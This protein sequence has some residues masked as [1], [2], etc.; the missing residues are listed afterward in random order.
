MDYPADPLS[1]PANETCLHQQVL[2][3]QKEVCFPLATTVTKSRKG[4]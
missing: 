2:L 3:Q 1:L 4:G